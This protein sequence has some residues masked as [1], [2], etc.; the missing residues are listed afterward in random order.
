MNPIP[1]LTFFAI[2]LALAAIPGAS[3]GLVVSRSAT[4]GFR[5]G[6]AVAGGIVLGDLALG[7]LAIYGMSNLAESMGSMF[8]LVR[9]LAGSYLIWIGIGLLRTRE[10]PTANALVEKRPLTLA[11]SF[12]SGLF[13]TF[14]D[15]KAIL[16]YASLFPTL[17]NLRLLTSIDIGIIATITI[18]TVGGVKLIYAYAART[19]VAHWKSSRMQRI[20]RKAAG[21]LM[22]GAGSYVI[23][24]A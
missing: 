5:N 2:M 18:V 23:L 14:G 13:L 22:I 3:V 9:C 17:F 16:F 12:L 15:L 6:A 21:G 10:D 19:F 24:K 8:F 11:S 4:L 1:F 20:T 7:A